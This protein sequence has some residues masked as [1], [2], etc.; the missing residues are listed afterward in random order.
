MRGV[1]VERADNNGPYLWHRRSGIGAPGIREIAHFARVASGQP[2]RCILQLGNL[3]WSATQV[4]F[5][6]RII[7]KIV[8]QRGGGGESWKQKKAACG[9][10]WANQISLSKAP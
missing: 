4:E 7:Q 9:E 8:P 2:L 10:I 1:V 5:G 3:A 6:S